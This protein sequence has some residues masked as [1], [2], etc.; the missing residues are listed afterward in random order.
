VS[1]RGRF[2]ED[3]AIGQ[4]FRHATPRTLSVGDVALYTALTGSRFAVNASDEFARAIGFKAAPLDDLLVFHIVFGRTVADV[5]LNAVANL[6]YAE[7]RFGVPV[8]AG[9]TLSATSSV[10]GLKENVGRGTGIVWVRSRG[11]NQ[12]GEMVVEFARWVMIPKRDATAATPAAQVPEFAEVVSADALIVPD[13]LAL[14]GYDFALAGDARRW[15]DYRVGERI[16]HI[17]GQTVEEAEHALATR[18]YQNPARIHFDKRLAAA[19]RFGRRLVYGGHVMSVAR[20]LSFEGLANA[21]KLVAVNG[22]RHV[23]PIQAGDTLY[24]WS[25]IRAA[26]E[27]PGRADVGALRLVT[28]ATK[29]AACDGFP[30][31]P[32]AS[33]TASPVVLVWDYTVLVPR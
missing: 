2:F 17:A 25:E 27:L 30:A 12:R 10:V 5:S 15:G 22:G 1:A 33:D 14:R 18:L 29:D 16:D 23:A 8:Y 11:L 31:P 9:D 19:S 28:I 21:F 32:A 6:G 4:E 3:F 7:L 20:A 26:W 13:G 24:A